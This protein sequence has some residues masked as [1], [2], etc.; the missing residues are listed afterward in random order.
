M[1][2]AP[3][4][5]AIPRSQQ[6]GRELAKEVL[7]V[8][9]VAQQHALRVVVAGSVHRLRQVDDDGKVHAAAAICHA[10]VC[11]IFHCAMGQQD[12]ELGQITMH[13]A[14]AQHAHHLGNQRA[15]VLQRL[16]GRK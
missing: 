16:L 1:V 8:V 5:F 3:D 13:H 15:V 7:E 9:H 2:Q 11:A 14:C 12:I 6:R 4:F 10:V